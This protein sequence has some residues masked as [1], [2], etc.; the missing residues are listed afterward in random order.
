MVNASFSTIKLLFDRGGSVQHGQLLHFAA[1]R[2]QPD[3]V[4]VLDFILSKGV[5]GMN[6]RMHQHR[7]ANYY[8]QECVGLSTPLEWAATAGLLDTVQHLLRHGADPSIKNSRGGL[9]IK[10]AAYHKHHDIAAVLSEYDALS[11]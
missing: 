9:R 11:T 5:P 2:T 8:M 3:H 6:K 1:K 7:P 10:S 4:E